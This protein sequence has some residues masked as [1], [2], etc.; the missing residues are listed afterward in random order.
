MNIVHRP[1]IYLK[2]DVSPTRFS[3]RL[4]VEPNQLDT[5]DRTSLF[6]SVSTDQ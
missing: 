3:F 5:I 6:L 4:Q 2:H 1:V